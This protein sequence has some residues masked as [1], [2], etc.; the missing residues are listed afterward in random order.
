[1][2][3]WEKKLSQTCCKNAYSLQIFYIDTTA[4]KVEKEVKDLILMSVFVYE[5]LSWRL[6]ANTILNMSAAVLHTH[7][8]FLDQNMKKNRLQRCKLDNYH[9]RR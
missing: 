1:M 4:F 9:P 7:Q 6:Q 3:N 8:S 5:T 2:K